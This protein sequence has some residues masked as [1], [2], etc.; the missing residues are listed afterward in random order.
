MEFMVSQCD[1]DDKMEVKFSLVNVGALLIE[2]ANRM[3]LV[4]SL[5]LR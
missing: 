1:I 2:F 3:A 4:A 5:N